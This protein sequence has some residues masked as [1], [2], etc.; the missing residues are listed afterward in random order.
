MTIDRLFVCSSS[1]IFLLTPFRV[2]H[3][4]LFVN[5]F[6]DNLQEN[7]FIFL[8][9]IE[10]VFDLSSTRARSIFLFIND[11]IEISHI[12]LTENITFRFFY[13]EKKTTQS[14]EKIKEQRLSKVD[15]TSF[16]GDSNFSVRDW[17]FLFFIN[18]C[19]ELNKH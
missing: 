15:V 19:S 6:F 7:I 13:F 18:V 9:M 12:A 2:L 10:F 4:R 14:Q 8:F 17:T 5:F 11:S 1:F 16:S 3:Q